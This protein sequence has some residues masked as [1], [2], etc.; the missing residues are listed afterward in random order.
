MALIE[1]NECKAAISDSA[2][3]CPQCGNRKI[4]DFRVAMAPVKRRARAFGTFAA[5]WFLGIILISA[6]AKIGA[7]VVR[8]LD[9]EQAA[10]SIVASESPPRRPRLAACVDRGTL[11]YQREQAWPTLP[12]GRDAAEVIYVACNISSR[13]FD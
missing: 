2:G 11:K 4:R 9:K 10:R 3:A 13:A 5:Q 8:H 12:D 1:C 6:V 7:L